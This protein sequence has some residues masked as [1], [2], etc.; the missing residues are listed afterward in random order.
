MRDKLLRMP[1]S[2]RIGKYAWIFFTSKFDGDI[3]SDHDMK[4]QEIRG[5]YP[6]KFILIGE[7][8]EEKLSD[9]HSR[10]LAGRV[11]QVTDNAKDIQQAYRKC[12]Q[13]GMEVLYALPSTPQDFI[14]ENIL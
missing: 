4:W 5:K 3:L 13:Q 6:D 10:A 9:S 12:Q 1:D 8:V 14:V 2:E 7:L 11:L